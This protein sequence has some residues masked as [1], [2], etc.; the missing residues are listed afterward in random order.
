MRKQILLTAAAIFLGTLALVGV[1]KAYAAVQGQSLVQM[2]ASRFNLNPSDVQSVFDQ[3]RGQQQQVRRQN[4]SD[5]LEQAVKDGKI[6]ESQ[7]ALILTKLSEFQDKHKTDLQNWKNM[8]SDQRKAA[9]QSQKQD[10]QNWATQ[11]GIDFNVLRP[12]L[13]GRG[14]K[15][16]MM[17]GWG[18][19]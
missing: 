4:L 16:G 10:L 9:Q 11:N 17:R 8:T 6:T 15:M 19:K 13:G 2:M 7:K 1:G 5:R 3:Y 12:Y 18:F 14:M